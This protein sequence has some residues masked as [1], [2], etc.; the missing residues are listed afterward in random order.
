[1]NN[2]L[3][4][5]LGN[6][7]EKAIANGVTVTL[8]PKTNVVYPFDGSLVS[9]FFDQEERLLSCACGRKDW[10]EV[11]VHESCH[12]DQWIEGCN[13][14][15]NGVQSVDDYFEWLDGKECK[16]IEQVVIN[17]A[18]L[19]ADCELRSI[20]KIK[21]YDLDID[22]RRYAKKANA[23]VYFYLYSLNTRRWYDPEKKPYDDHW[24]LSQ[25]PSEIDLAS[26]SKGEFPDRLFSI[27]RQWDC[28]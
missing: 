13:A 23:Y 10:M 22:T 3:G 1:M 5:L 18:M 28:G 19:E 21:D 26:L 15:V 8:S 24:L 7:L 20:K 9:G 6:V 25:C 27:F 2:N 16:N 17:A 11:F 12:M 4:V 14:W